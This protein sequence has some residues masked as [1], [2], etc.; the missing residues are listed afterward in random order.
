MSG[1]PTREQVVLNALFGLTE[2]LTKGSNLEEVLKDVA[3]LAYK[4]CHASTCSVMVLDESR[5]NLLCRVGVGLPPSEIKKATF[6][7]GEGIAGWVVRNNEPLRLADA[8]TDPRF[9]SIEGQLTQIRGMCCVPLATPE[10]VTGSITVTSPDAG[11][12]TGEDQAVLL[13]LAGAIAHDLE[14]A[15]IY[16][17]AVTDPVT[18]AY[19]RQYLAKRLPAEVERQRRYG[20]PLSIILMGLDS[21]EGAVEARELAGVNAMAHWLGSIASDLIR[22]VDS[23]V[24]YSNDEFL[25]LLP[26]S[27]ARGAERVAERVRKK[28]SETS[29][30]VGQSS[31]EVTASLGLAQFSGEFENGE[32]LL[33]AAGAALAQARAQGGN[34]VRLAPGKKSEL[35]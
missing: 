26:T 31:F 35:L 12:F 32:E 30:T 5:E 13:F 23:L 21:V 29:L 33:D 15:R 6:K 1:N 24:R 9:L 16:R 11:I 14:N 10:G 4:L 27:D 18:G 22:E 34:C 2:R 19:N 8:P 3:R 7:V 17:M 20:Q 28:V 25:L